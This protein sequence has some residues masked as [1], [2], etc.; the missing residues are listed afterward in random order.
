[1][2]MSSLAQSR[3]KRLLSLDSPAGADAA[4]WDTRLLDAALVGR[5]EAV[6]AC[7]AAGANPAARDTAGLTPLMLAA[8]AGC[9]AC[10]ERLL[11]V[12]R[13]DDLD[14]S[15]RD[16]AEMAELGSNPETA[17]RIRAFMSSHAERE[18]LGL[19]SQPAKRKPGRM[20]L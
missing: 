17:E 7:L 18:A 12:S 13:L 4:E 10:V 11:P 9:E 8:M 16:A 15:G 20:G 3:I 1:M 5:E 2:G 19:A 14:P 6:A